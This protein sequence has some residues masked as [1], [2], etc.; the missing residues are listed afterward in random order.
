MGRI[1]GRFAR[2]MLLWT[3]SVFVLAA[4]LAAQAIA[5]LLAAQQ[6]CFFYYP[7]VPCATGNDPAVTRLTLAFFG[8]PVL[9][10]AGICLAVLGRALL[11]RL[12]V[13]TR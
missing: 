13:R 4:L 7:Q 2:G 6:R 9:W 3:L 11:R 1:R 8:L 12:H 10:L 5:S